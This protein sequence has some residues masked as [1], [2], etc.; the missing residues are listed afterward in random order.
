MVLL[1]GVLAGVAF[2]L[3]PLARSRA[4]NVQPSAPDPSVVVDGFEQA[5]NRRDVDAML[6]FFTDDATLTD[7]TGRVYQG[8]T[9]IRGYFQQLNAR[10]RG[11][12]LGVVNRQVNGSEVSWTERPPVQNAVGFEIGVSA[13]VRKQRS[14]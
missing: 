9:D 2:V 1:V 8:K 6:T 11:L 3:Q 7:R 12:T 10:G 14:G 4:L 5:R 13:V